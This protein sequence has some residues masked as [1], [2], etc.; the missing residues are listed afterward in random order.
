MVPFLTLLTMCLYSYTQE[1]AMIGKQL[2]IYFILFLFKLRHLAGYLF[3][4]DLEYISLF[5]L[6]KLVLLTLSIPL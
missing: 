3:G 1:V 2:F 4:W 6:L 5:M